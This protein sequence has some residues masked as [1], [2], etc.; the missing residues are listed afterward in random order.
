[1]DIKLTSYFKSAIDSSTKPTINFKDNDFAILSFGSL[2]INAFTEGEIKDLSLLLTQ[3]EY[4][5]MYVKKYSVLKPWET[6]VSFNTVI[7]F[8]TLKSNFDNQNRIRKEIDELTGVFYIPCRLT[9]KRNKFGVS[10]NCDKPNNTNELPWFA[11]KFMKPT[12]SNNIPLITSVEKADQYLSDSTAIR[13]KI[14]NWSDY[15][16]YCQR[17]FFSVT[18]PEAEIEYESNCF[19][20]RYSL[21]NTTDA[22]M[23]IY[24]NLLRQDIEHPLYNKFMQFENEPSSNLI[25]ND[26]KGAMKCHS[27]NMDGVYSLSDSQR[28]AIN[29]LNATKNGEI[30]AVSGPPGTGKTTLLQTVVADMV[31]KSVLKKE[32][33]PIII[34]TS[35]N[36]QAV[37]NIIDSF[38]KIN[39]VG[40]SNIEHRWID[41]VH[42][43]AVYFPSN[44]KKDEAERKNYHYT[45]IRS[46]EFISD[47]QNKIQK[48]KHL[49]LQ[50]GKE[51]FGVSFNDVNS[52]KDKLYNTLDFINE[53][54]NNLLDLVQE[55]EAFCENQDAVSYLNSLKKIKEDSEINVARYTRRCSYWKDI[56]DKISSFTK[57]FSFI[58]YFANKMKS[59]IQIN[60]LPEELDFITDNM[61]FNSV[62][63]K[64]S[65]LILNEKYKINL[66]N[67]KIEFI[68]NHISIIKLV[69]STL[70]SKNC[71]LNII[72]ENGDLT[73]CNLYEIN[74]MVD[75]HIR[76]M[77]FWLAVHINECRF[78]ESEYAA[79]GK[80]RGNTYKNILENFY[81]QLALLTPCMVMTLY[82][83]PNNFCSLDHGYMYDFIDLL[84]IDEAGQCSPEIAAPSFSLA[85]KAIVVGDEMQ[86]PPVWNIDYST[87]VLLAVQNKV[88]ETPEDFDLLTDN[89]LNVSESSVMRI[90]CKSCKFNKYDRGLF[91][92]E[93][94]RCYD[95]IINYC[96]ELVYNGNLIPCKGSGERSNYPLDFIRYP[97]IG[98]YN[99]YTKNSDKMSSS[100]VNKNEAHSIAVWI[101][102]HYDEIYSLYK[103]KFTDIKDNEILAVITPFKAQ[104]FAIKNELKSVIGEDS[105]NITVG[106]VH[107][108]QGSDRRIIIFSTVYGADDSCFFIDN[109]KNLMNVAVSRAKDAFWVFGSNDCMNKKPIDTASGLL[110]SY[111]V[112]NPLYD[113]SKCQE[114]SI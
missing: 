106:T 13:N 8:K 112:N 98:F 33:P 55:T 35:S 99:I 111:I 68:E 42:S 37:T 93:H 76:Y 91:L 6:V 1:M 40:I 9:F 63:S 74:K 95:E 59:E 108:F 44:R 82:T 102:N 103:S 71:D 45:G 19:I 25:S 5:N 62:L 96:N 114:V 84:I 101:K 49:L 100:R 11:R 54:K 57:L 27:G 10:V 15:I 67:K 48:N 75:K 69:L 32:T 21:L 3:S 81:H 18:D 90:A 104:A 80:Q 66:L 22:L 79:K 83:A 78:I 50:N 2:E 65:E 16:D 23:R 46:C 60:I 88:I 28:E 86:I 29:H 31:V 47:M 36:N 24:E 89:G 12:I 17:Y 70:K 113:K 7:S 92:S 107:T 14:E 97:F 41:G 110:N 87:D 77:E 52:L 105:N 109:N 56:F 20:F 64:Y 58:P 4:N 85:K 51:Y 53:C 38:G 39:P 43:F 30:L 34:A 72:S 26:D 94:R 73:L 61:T